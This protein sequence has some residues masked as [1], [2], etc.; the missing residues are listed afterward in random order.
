MIVIVAVGTGTDDRQEVDPK[1]KGLDFIKQQAMVDATKNGFAL[2][3][4]FFKRLQP[5]SPTSLRVYTVHYPGGTIHSKFVLGDDEVLSV[6]S[7]NANPRGFIFDTEVNVVLEHPETVRAFRHQLW[8]HNLGLPVAEVAKWNPGDFFTGWDTVAKH[9]LS[10]EMMPE[11][12]VGERVIPF[13]PW[14]PKDPRYRAGRRGPIR[15][16]AL[17]ADAPEG[18]F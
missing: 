12:M 17:Q 5:L 4:E 2:R 9:N 18:L 15:L 16:G 13:E 10:V 6:G 8:A 7:A 14:N 11:A 3:L 1:A